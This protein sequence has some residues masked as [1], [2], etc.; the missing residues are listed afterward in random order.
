MFGS[1][2]PA[3][4]PEES[5]SD[6]VDEPE[7]LP[8]EEERDAPIPLPRQ[9]GRPRKVQEPSMTRKV[10]SDPP[11]V[12]HSAR[13]AAINTNPLPAAARETRIR[14]GK[15]AAPAAEA[16]NK[17][18]RPRKTQ[19]VVSKPTAPPKKTGRKPN[20]VKTAAVA[21]AA[22]AA[23]DAEI[24]KGAPAAGKRGRGRPRRT[25]EA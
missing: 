11:P 3:D 20:T 16:P 6:Q 4:A 18:G 23:L 7:D 14:A 19:D 9:R 1:S 17:R 21:V 24:K 2:E 12:R 13:I 25:H 5:Y 8:V 15:G 22:A 10:L